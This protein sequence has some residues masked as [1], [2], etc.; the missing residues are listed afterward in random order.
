MPG[1][2]PDN[3]KINIDNIENII[4]ETMKQYFELYGFDVSTPDSRRKITHNEITHCLKYIYN[5]I[6]SCDI[7]LCNDQNSRFDYNDIILLNHLANIYID[8]ALFF[9]KSIGLMQ[10]G[11]MIGVAPNT[12][13]SWLNDGERNPARVQIL[14]NIQEYHKMSHINLLNQ[15]PVGA[16]AVANN[17]KETGLE[18]TKNNAQTINNNSV[19]IL[20]SERRK[21]LNNAQ[22]PVSV[23]PL[24]VSVSDPV[25]V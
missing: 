8:I 13:L 15:S 17:D 1:V 25:D 11:L 22:G 9:N 12:L 18:W 14:N 4:H 2:V 5:N 16:L 3:I 19:F 20:P 7:N 21:M 6:F 23:S 10:F 24:P